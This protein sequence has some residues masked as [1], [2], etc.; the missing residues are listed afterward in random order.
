MCDAVSLKESIEKN[1]YEMGRGTGFV[2]S[3]KVTPI[4]PADKL[5]KALSRFA[6]IDIS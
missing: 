5:C 2:T 6:N 1:G 3:D 4:T